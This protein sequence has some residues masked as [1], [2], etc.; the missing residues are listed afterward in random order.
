M[1]NQ[2]DSVNAPAADR[3]SEVA[4]ILALGVLRLRSRRLVEGVENRPEGE[5]LDWTSQPGR[6]CVTSVHDKP[7]ES[8][9]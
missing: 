1:S 9:E 8:N 3:L 7:H 4:R 5:G 6:A 2:G